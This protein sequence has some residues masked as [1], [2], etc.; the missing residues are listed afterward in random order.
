MIGY[1]DHH[2]TADLD[3][4]VDT[5]VA[6]KSAGLPIVAGLEVDYYP[7][8]MDKV[9]SK[10]LDGYPFDVLLGSIHWLG[11]WMFDIV[12]LSGPD[13][14]VGPTWHRRCV[15]V[16]R[17]GDRGAG[18]HWDCDASAHPDL[19]KVTGRRPDVGLVRRSRS[20]SPRRRPRAGWLPSSSSAGWRKPVREAYPTPDL[21]K[22]FNDL[23]VPLTTAS[24]T[25]G[26]GNVAN[27]CPQLHE[28]AVSAGYSTLRAFRLRRGVDVPLGTLRRGRRRT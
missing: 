16:L 10:C 17:R 7:G 12:V 19:V 9:E 5:V 22:R 26:V 1:F 25:H 18:R 11:T 14:G 20:R 6:A 15:E 13:G 3:R 21:L 27:R 4:Y 24:D 8:L 2:A 23:G 28:L